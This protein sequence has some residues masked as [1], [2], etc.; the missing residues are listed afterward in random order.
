M[1]A[2]QSI[3]DKYPWI[4][5]VADECRQERFKNMT[6]AQA[7][8][9][10]MK[11]GHRVLDLE[12]KIASCHAQSLYYA[13]HVIKGRFLEGESAIANKAEYASAYAIHVLKQRWPEGEPAILISPYCTYIY[14]K[15]I[16]MG[17]WPEGEEKLKGTK[18]W[19]RYVKV[20]DRYT[21]RFQKEFPFPAAGQDN[22]EPI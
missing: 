2:K 17:V 4:K 6:P 8:D 3:H 13:L 5:K 22:L 16:M 18:Y 11:A 7:L 9:Y 21:D 10:A 19:K 1:T 20:I 14:A 15:E 12:P